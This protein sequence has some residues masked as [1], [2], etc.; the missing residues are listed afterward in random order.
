MAKKVRQKPADEAPKFEFPEFDEAGFVAKE[1]ELAAGL[2]LAGGLTLVL[3]A[4]AWLL[5]R[6]GVPWDEVFL[7]GILGI[8]VTPFLIAR[9]RSRSG[10][11]TKG[12]WAGFV[13]L[14]FFGW[15]ALWF[16]LINLTM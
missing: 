15:L 7:I 5:T 13:M 2:Y 16:V 10:L 1:N 6:S 9:L 12:D 14:E 8:A 11:F 3:G 4:I